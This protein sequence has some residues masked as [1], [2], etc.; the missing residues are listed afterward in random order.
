VIGRLLHWVIVSVDGRQK[1]PVAGVADEGLARWVAQVRQDSGPSCREMGAQG[2]RKASRRRA[3]SR[4][5]G[6]QLPLVQ[7]LRTEAG[8][9]LRL[10]RPALQPRPAVLYLHGGGFVM[11]DL[12]SHDSTCRRLARTADVMVLAVD[13][14]LAPEDP[15]PAAVE[16]AVSAYDWVAEHLADLGG[17]LAAGVA[18][19]GD[20]SGGAVALLAAVRL[21]DAGRLPSALLLA[22]PNVDMTLA[23]PSVDQ[24]GHGWGLEAEDLCWF[25]EQW[26]PDPDCRNDPIVSPRHADL[27][28]LPPTVLATAEHDPLR[29]EGDALVR[30]LREGNVDVEHLPHPGLVHGFLGLGHL[31]P[32]AAQAGEALFARFGASLRQAPPEASVSACAR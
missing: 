23:Q 28:A 17:D 4:P 6:P 5:R 11:G 21:R 8:L 9:P 26:V 30:Q 20:S 10:Y 13:Y 12:D 2:L 3:G 19:A 7:D 14:R 32:A 29:D 22:Y 1:Q 18:L 27:A 16:D 24:Q 25:V 31:S 15:G